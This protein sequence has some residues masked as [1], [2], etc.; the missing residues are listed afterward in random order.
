[1]CISGGSGFQS[2]GR[3]SWPERASRR[4]SQ[5]RRILAAYVEDTVTRVDQHGRVQHTHEAVRAPHVAGQ[6]LSDLW[7]PRCHWLRRSSPSRFVHRRNSPLCSQ[8]H[9]VH[10]Q[11]R[12]AHA[13][14]PDGDHP[15]MQAQLRT[16]GFGSP[17]VAG[18]QASGTGR[19]YDTSSWLKGQDSFTTPAVL[20]SLRSLH[21]YLL[22]SSSFC[23]DTRDRGGVDAVWGRFSLRLA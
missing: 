18:S 4:A 15:W 19:I 16:R 13:F 11:E 14:T 5:A 1:M 9:M 12:V 21:V 3:R 20:G 7:T 6:R 10:Y 22:L 17:F 8:E 23:Y 2:R